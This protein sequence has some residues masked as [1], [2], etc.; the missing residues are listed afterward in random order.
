M[1]VVDGDDAAVTVAPGTPTKTAAS[2]ATA[3]ATTTATPTHQVTA[4]SSSSSSV[5]MMTTTAS[6]RPKAVGGVAPASASASA[7]E[8]AHRVISCQQCGIVVHMGCLHDFAP[9]AVAGCLATP[10]TPWL[11]MLCATNSDVLT[12]SCALCPRHGGVFC[13][14]VDQTM[15]HPYC[16]RTL[17][18]QMSIVDGEYIDMKQHVKEANRKQKCG[19]CNRKKGLC[20]P[21]DRARIVLDMV[22]KRE[23]FKKMICK[24][25]LDLFQHRWQK[26][27]ARATGKKA[28]SSHLH[29]LDERDHILQLDDS[30]E[31]SEYVYSDGDDGDD[32]M[33]EE[34][35][36]QF[37]LTHGD[38]FVLLPDFP[39]QTSGKK[40]EALPFV[41]PKTGETV[42]ISPTWTKYGEIRRPKNMR[43]AFAG[44]QLFPRDI[45]GL[46]QKSF[47]KLQLEKVHRLADETRVYSGIFAH[48]KEEETFGKKLLQDL[49]RQSQMTD[50]ELVEYLRENAPFLELP[51]SLDEI[52]ALPSYQE[53]RKHFHHETAAT[54]STKRRTAATA[55]PT[56]T[57]VGGGGGFKAIYDAALAAAAAEGAGLSTQVPSDTAVLS[58]VYRS[59]HDRSSPAF[60]AL[61]RI[62]FHV[63]DSLGLLEDT[64]PE[65][66]AALAEERAAQALLS[67]KSRASAKEQKKNTKKPKNQ[68]TR[69]G[70]PMRTRLQAHQYTSIAAYAAD[71]Y[72]LMN[73]ARVVATMTN[74][75]IRDNTKRL[76]EQFERL[77][78]DGLQY[79]GEDDILEGVT[80][81]YEHAPLRGRPQRKPRRSWATGKAAATAAAANAEWFCRACVISQGHELIGRPVRVWWRGDGC[82]YAGR[83]DG[84]DPRAQCHRI[85][86][87]VDQEWEFVSL[88][89]EPYLFSS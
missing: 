86:Y 78:W 35:D 49:Y 19:I 17:T 29:P 44:H 28:A 62:L 47:V 30:S 48:R 85:L 77:V 73:N 5:A 75:R 84:Y 50:K 18:S 14:T 13:P 46:N 16:A 83:I 40:Y 10:P 32:A 20:L 55:A 41:H 88:A 21:L 4:S 69:G 63:H 79:S 45:V 11:C 87:D 81:N 51:R 56:G 70:A 71:F 42:F 24:S 38:K 80:T 23:K 67:P 12:M 74:T 58:D 6:P 68:K 43:I 2:D 53:F 61:E 22:V 15:V 66:L 25:E 27:L 82:A 59:I 60:I 64:H 89:L 52:R 8:H 9:A 36:A 65:T 54:T 76:A 33:D 72:T 31:A 34:I 57:R 1:D 39:Q 37:Q 3:P 7:S 26:A